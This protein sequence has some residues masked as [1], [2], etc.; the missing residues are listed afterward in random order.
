M[1]TQPLPQHVLADK[2]QTS[3]SSELAEMLSRAMERI[4]PDLRL[5]FQLK[6]VEEL[7]YAQIGEIAGIPEGT[8]GSRLNRARR[9][10][11]DQ[12]LNLG[13]EP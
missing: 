3:M 4:E 1:K 13:W 10:L 12:L 8:V 11:R 6:E 9:E 7:S 2:D 5:I